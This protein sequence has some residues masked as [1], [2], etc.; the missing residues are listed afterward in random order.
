M[1]AHRGERLLP[2]STFRELADNAPVMIWRAGPDQLCDWFNKPWLDFTGRTME[3]EQGFG[4]A[5]GVHPDDL[6]RCVGI[7][8]SA[9]DARESFSMIYRLRRRDGAYRWLLDKGAPFNRDGQFAGYFGSCLDVTEQREAHD[10]LVTALDQRDHLISEVY[11]RVKNNLQ[12]IEG[13]LAIEGLSLPDPA[14]KSALQSISARVRAMGAVHQLLIRSQS[15][16]HIRASD[17]LSG[18]CADIGRAHNLE[19]RGIAL[20]VEAEPRDVDID[21]ALIIGLLV[22]ELA[23]NAFKHAFPDG[24]TGRVRVRFGAFDGPITALEV[25]D[26]G[27]GLAD[28]ALAPGRPKRSGFRLVEGFVGQL[29]GRL[30]VDR[31]NGATIRIDLPQLARS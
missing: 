26:D 28:E 10:Q 4:W 3:Q 22:N 30:V 12:Q 25:S 17:F 20:E 8:T 27:V 16:S 2:E 6:D 19:K 23:T 14:A 21:S 9:F 13:L 24:R 11:H 7:Y 1:A 31:R 18:L 15:L 29:D 5:E